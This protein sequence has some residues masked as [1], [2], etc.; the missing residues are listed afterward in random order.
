MPLWDMPSQPNNSQPQPTDTEEP[1]EQ[2]GGAKI[3]EKG[4]LEY[5]GLFY[6]PGQYDQEKVATGENPILPDYEGQGYPTLEEALNSLG[7]PVDN[8][9]YDKMQ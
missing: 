9:E 5:E 8:F 2:Q 7:T 4:I 1:T 6:L 3:L